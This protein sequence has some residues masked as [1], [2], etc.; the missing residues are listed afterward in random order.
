MHDVAGF[1][2]IKPRGATPFFE[3]G[4]RCL[5]G[6]SV[7][8]GREMNPKLKVI[9][10]FVKLFLTKQFFDSHKYRIEYHQASRILFLQ[11]EALNR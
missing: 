9:V 1:A 8:R 10:E 11:I 5:K 2:D 7:G 6:L 3:A 4:W